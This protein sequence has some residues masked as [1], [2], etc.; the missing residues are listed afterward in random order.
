[1]NLIHTKK[2]KQGMTLIEVM[3]GVF[4][5]LL[6]GL[7]IFEFQKSVFQ[8]ESILTGSLDAS[9]EANKAVKILATEIREAGIGNDGSYPI[10]VADSDEFIFFSDIN[11][12]GLKEKIRYYLDNRYLKKQV[13]YFSGNPPSYGD[14]NESKNV[15]NYLVNDTEPVFYFYDHDYSGTEDALETPVDIL[16]IRLV[17]IVLEIDKD[18]AKAPAPLRAET[19]VTLRILKD[20]R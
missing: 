6:I 13:S 3:I 11:N 16:Q 19:N 4:I 10:L 15:I 2:Y 14:Y 5:L 9:Y 17:K 7:A 20:N 8:T 1:M 12:D 18:D